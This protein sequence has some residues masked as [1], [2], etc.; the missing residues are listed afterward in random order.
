MSEL[1][2]YLAAAS[3]FADISRAMLHAAATGT[4]T[5]ELKPDRTFVTTTDRA[6][7][8]RLR[9]KER[10]GELRL[11]GAFFAISDGVLHVLDEAEGTFSPVE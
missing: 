4:G 5:A 11:T 3:E 9:E 8:Q 2:A 6:I 10:S 1:D 7:E